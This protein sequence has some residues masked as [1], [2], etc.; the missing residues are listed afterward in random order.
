MAEKNIDYKDSLKTRHGLDSASRIAI[1]QALSGAVTEDEAKWRLQEQL[2]GLDQ[3][4]RVNKPLR[5]DEAAWTDGWPKREQDVYVPAVADVL[6]A[7]KIKI[8]KDDGGESARKEF[9][10]LY[11]SKPDREAMEKELAKTN[12]R[13]G[14]GYAKKVLEL[15]FRQAVKDQGEVEL[16][17]ARE[18]AMSAKLNDPY[19]WYASLAGHTLLRNMYNA[20]LE[21]RDPTAADILSDASEGLLFAVPGGAYARGLQFAR[22]GALGKYGKWAGRGLGEATAPFANEAL[23]Y[24]LHSNDALEETGVNTWKPWDDGPMFSDQERTSEA[25]FSPERAALGAMTNMGIGMSLYQL[26]NR[27]AQALSGDLT[28]GA[29]SRS[30]REG[31]EGAKTASQTVKEAQNTA[32]AVQSWKAKD[33]LDAFLVGNEKGISNSA[34]SDAEGV[35]QF[36]KKAGD[37]KVPENIPDYVRDNEGYID[38]LLDHNGIVGGER[39]LFKRT[40]LN[41]PELATL[42]KSN[43]LKTAL[44]RFYRNT[45][46]SADGPIRSELINKAGRNEHAKQFASRIGEVVDVRDL[47]KQQAERELNNRRAVEN[48]NLRARQDLDETDRKYLEQVIK[49]PKMVQFSNDTGFKLWLLTRGNDILRGTSYYRPTWDTEE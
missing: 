1:E 33:G 31:I 27:G 47:A 5:E 49:N 8:S 42:V 36:K 23:Q 18:D 4:G 28:R 48:E 43:N 35:L 11:T 14:E 12:P 38:A 9:I 6:S 7:P 13:I 46:V 21:G 25:T 29:Q 2:F 17:R 3:Y 30:V 44:Q 15:T 41:H 19:S 22:L 34:I 40:L 10:K 32:K 24:A 26:G 39:E 20:G 37:L 16:Q 45:V